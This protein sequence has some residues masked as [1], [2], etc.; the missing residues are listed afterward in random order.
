[1]NISNLFIK[2]I[3]DLLSG[4]PWYGR[5]MAAILREISSHQ[6]IQK[7]NPSSKTIAQYVAHILAWRGF[8]VK[9][10]KGEESYDIVLQNE[11]DWPEIK[12]W[13]SSSW[14]AMQLALEESNRELI[15]HLE[16]MSDSDF[17]KC[18]PGKEYTLEYALIG[19]LQHDVYHL[20]QIS[21]LA[22]Q[23]R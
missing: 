22:Q 5:S 20:G 3:S 6:A 23:L 12:S 14:T 10:L 7:V 15:Y 1:M 19:L 2:S 4:D 11:E 18:V 9:K 13:N 16:R 17:L 21:T 8:M